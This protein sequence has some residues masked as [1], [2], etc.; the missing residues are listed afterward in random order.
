MSCN[1]QIHTELISI[2]ED[3]CPFCDQLLVKAEKVVESCCSEQNMVNK[4]GLH[5]CINC[6]SVHNSAYYNE[7]I[8]VHENIHRIKRKSVYHRKY[9][10]ENLL[11]DISIK[12]NIQITPQQ[13]NQIYKIFVEIGTV[14]PLLNNNRKRTISIKFII[15]QLFMLMNI[16]FDFIKITK[17]KQTLK[18]YEKYWANIISLIGDKIKSIIH[19]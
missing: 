15:K 13:R 9:H 18:L 3:T 14:I 11:N 8:D 2:D 16:P 6:G 10:I 12:N 5:T 19:S 7:Y 4:D 1:K 17:S